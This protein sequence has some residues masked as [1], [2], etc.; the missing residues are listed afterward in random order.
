MKYCCVKQ[1]DITDCGA[2]F[3]GKGCKR[4]SGG[5]LL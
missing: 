3:Y 1:C 2:W 4:Q 5:V